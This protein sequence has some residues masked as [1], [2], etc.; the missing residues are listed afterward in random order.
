MAEVVGLRTFVYESAFAALLHVVAAASGVVAYTGEVPHVVHGPDDV[1]AGFGHA[2]YAPER[3]HALIDPVEH[4]HVSLFYQRM[5]L[6]RQSVAACA[7]LE[8]CGTIE[9]VGHEYFQMLLQ[10]WHACAPLRCGKNH[11][12]VGCGFVNHQHLYVCALGTKCLHQPIAYYRGSAAHI[13][14]VYNYNFHLR[15]PG[16]GICSF[17]MQNTR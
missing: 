7:Y 10:K 3:Q 9:T 1:F 6:Q 2:A 8:Q 14:V 13:A 5:A 17:L 15:S 11:I 16:N 4:H 12:G